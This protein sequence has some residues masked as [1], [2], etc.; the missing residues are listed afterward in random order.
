M[1]SVLDRI[2]SRSEWD[3]FLYD[4]QNRGQPD[5][6]EIE[7]IRT[8]IEERRYEEIEKRLAEKNFPGEY[9]I[10]KTINKEGTKKKRIV[11]SFGEENQLALKFIANRLYDF[12]DFFSGNC[13]AFRRNYGVGNA[14]LKILHTPS[15][16]SKYCYKA[17]I[18]NYFNSIDVERLLEKL[19][20]VEKADRRLYE[21]FYRILMEENVIENGVIKKENHGAMAGL[22]IAPFFANVYLSEIDRDFEKEGIEYFRYSDD[23]LIFADTYEE[24]QEKQKELKEKLEKHKLKINPEK[25]SISAPGEVWEFLGFSYDRGGLDLSANTKR[26]MK[27]KIKRKADALRRW[28]RKKALSGDKAAIGFIRAM[29]RKF[30]GWGD[31]D[32][33]DLTWSRWFF[34]YLSKDE[35]LKEIDRY[36]QEYIRFCVTG[37]H[38][39]GNYRISYDQMK[40]WGYLSLVHE[41]YRFREEKPC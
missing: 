38:Y 21:V 13:Y 16:Q 17:D 12:D 22:P 41:Y 29:N 25:E 5:K 30:Y 11:Y 6:K 28:Q 14:L 26:K 4:R 2:A 1:E 24:I 34:P 23:I 19:T 37:R 32:G 33:K 36:M 40:E 9:P 35:G 18:S 8:Y 31:E 7:Q 27:A 15:F 3:Q 10:K 20:F 39:K